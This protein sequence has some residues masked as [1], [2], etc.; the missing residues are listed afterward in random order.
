MNSPLVA[1][2][3][4]SGVAMV[5]PTV[6]HAEVGNGGFFV[7]GNIGRTSLNKGFGENFYSNDAGDTTGYGASLGYRW[8]L[9]PSIALGIEG[10]YANI[11]RFEPNFTVDTVLRRADLSGWNLG[12]NGHFSIAASW[13]VSARGGWFHGDVKGSHVTSLQYPP[14]DVDS[15]S[16]KY[17]AGVGFGYDFGKNVSIGLNYDRYQA[18]TDS[19]NFKLNLT[20]LSAE[21][22]F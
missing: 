19:L 10:G 22:R 18:N 21:Y 11:G 7:N 14:I 2:F 12:I 8:A 17:Y 1:C 20:S 9:N 16:N 13:Y 6:S 3:L 4:A 5:I 15:T